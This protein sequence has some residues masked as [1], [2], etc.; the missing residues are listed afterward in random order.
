VQPAVKAVATLRAR[1]GSDPAADRVLVRG[2]ARVHRVA[3][4]TSSR[5]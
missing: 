4:P 5:S 2:P 1:A 3:F